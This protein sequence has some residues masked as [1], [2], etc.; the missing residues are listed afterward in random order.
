MTSGRSQNELNPL[1]LVKKMLDRKRGI[2][3][4]DTHEQ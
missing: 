2:A 1:R 4:G 3:G